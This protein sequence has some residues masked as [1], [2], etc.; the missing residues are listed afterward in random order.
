MTEIFKIIKIVILIYFINFF[1]YGEELKDSL[2]ITSSKYEPYFVTLSLEKYEESILSGSIYEPSSIGLNIDDRNFP[3]DDWYLDVKYSRTIPD[4]MFKTTCS[5]ISNLLQLANSE[6]ENKF[7]DLK[8]NRKKL[9]GELIRLQD[10]YVNVTDKKLIKT[11]RFFTIYENTGTFPAYPHP[12]FFFDW[13]INRLIE[14]NIIKDKNK[15]T[16]EQKLE[17]EQYDQ[18][19]KFVLAAQKKWKLDKINYE[20]QTS[21]ITQQKETLQ[22][23]HNYL[24]ELYSL[25]PRADEELLELFS[26]SKYPAA[27][28]VKIL[29]ELKIPYK[30][31]RYWESQKRRFRTFAEFVSFDK[32]K[33]L[34]TL[35]KPNGKKTVVRFNSLRYEDKKY[36]QEQTNPQPITTTQPKP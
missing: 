8:I 13:N 35:E 2:A 17:L 3:F 11:N 22:E 19:F 9:A 36:V 26:K 21:L 32:R 30:K 25:E 27:E 23:S 12:T 28:K 31:F 5:N 24:V 14:L 20:L 6:G 18:K 29:M 33:N 10:F 1:V 4:Q 7:V 15:L 34:V 16:N